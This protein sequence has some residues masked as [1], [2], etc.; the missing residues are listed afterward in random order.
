M[1]EFARAFDD[2]VAADPME[3]LE[4]TAR[5]R[6]GRPSATDKGND[7]PSA[8]RN[9]PGMSADSLTRILKNSEGSVVAAGTT[10]V[11]ITRLAHALVRDPKDGVKAL[12]RWGRKAAKDPHKAL[13]ALA[14]FAEVLK[15]AVA[16]LRRVPQKFGNIIE[17]FKNAAAE[18]ARALDATSFTITF[19][20]PRTVS[21]AFSWST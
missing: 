15:R 21:L 9:Q 7:K 12:R 17:A 13:G 18:V 20:L 2:F 1:G 19:D 4:A 5:P 10:D 6:T 11:A 16:L 14:T 8:G 3:L